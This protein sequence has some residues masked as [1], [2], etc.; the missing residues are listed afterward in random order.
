MLSLQ[1][2]AIVISV[3]SIVYNTAEG[4]VSIVFGAESSSRSLVFF[5]VQ[6]AV[7]VISAL[8]VL[9]RFL[10]VVKPG[11]ERTT[12]VDARII[13]YVLKNQTTQ[14]YVLYF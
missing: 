11:E 9:W 3:L 6:S 2:Y 5:G 8:I 14:S 7:E 4:V 10:A 12:K 1:T 13:R